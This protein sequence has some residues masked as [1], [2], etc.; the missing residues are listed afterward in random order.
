MK[1]LDVKRDLELLDGLDGNT[2]LGRAC[3][4]LELA[5]I[6]HALAAFYVANIVDRKLHKP[7]GYRTIK[8]FAESGLRRGHGTV[9]NLL[10][11]GRALS[12]RRE[13]AAAVISGRM[14]RSH[15]QDLL[16]ILTPGNER[17]WVDWAPE[18][19]TTEV[20]RHVALRD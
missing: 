13:L 14:T 20:R 1:P 5:D 6:A 16:S 18:R 17:A 9:R 12:R 2:A 10:S 4:A 8:D 7:K 15:A 11:L 3:E 19:S